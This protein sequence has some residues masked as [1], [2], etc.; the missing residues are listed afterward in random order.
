MQRRNSPA[1]V[2]LAASLW[3][4]PAHA[5]PPKTQPAKAQPEE[6]LKSTQSQ[7]EE[8][9]TAKE[10][11]ATESKKVEAELASLQAELVK[12]AANAQKAESALSSAEEKLRILAAEVTIKEKQLK[13]REKHL[14]GLVQAS[15]SLSHTPPEAMVMMPGDVTHI[16][17]AARALKMASD[18]VKAETQS[19][20]LQLAELESMKAKLATDRDTLAARQK[21]MD[22]RQKEL[23]GKLAERKTLQKRFHA[24]AEA[25]ESR[26]SDLAKKTK[27]LKTLVAGVEEDRQEE[28][29]RKNARRQ[30]SMRSFADAKG[31]IRT[32]AGGRLTR[33]FG[34]PEGKNT[35]AKGITVRT[36]E[37]ASVVTPFDGEVVFTGP[38]LKYGQMVI[39]RHSDNFHTLLAGLEKIDVDVGQFLLEGEPIG[40]M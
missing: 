10:K 2:L 27:D 9:Q 18:G 31:H 39:V 21:E 11:I 23:V 1:L 24:E 14:S 33:R 29:R 13:T 40:A 12:L 25:T 15:I 32:P 34:S 4:S 19:L 3:L 17:K 7:L 30:G 5:K 8:A 37:G 35:T 36:R 6:E 26:L 20:A 38:F 28:A 22:T 16:M